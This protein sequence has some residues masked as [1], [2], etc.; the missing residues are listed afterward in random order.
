MYIIVKGK[1]SYLQERLLEQCEEGRYQAKQNQRLMSSPFRPTGGNSSPGYIDMSEARSLLSKETHVEDFSA[2]AD[3]F[4]SNPLR[5][6]A[7]GK[8][9]VKKGEL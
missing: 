7:Y 3:V 5:Y 9:G 4:K 8:S 1:R 6:E 2:V